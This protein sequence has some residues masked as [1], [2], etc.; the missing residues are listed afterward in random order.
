M[1]AN[2]D[3][4]VLDEA[5]EEG[6][7][8][9]KPPMADVIRVPKLSH[10]VA[11][12]L[13]SQIISGKLASGTMLA[14]ESKLLAI[15]DVSRPTLREA[16]RILEAEALIRIGRGMRAGAQILGPN[17]RKAAEYTTFMLVSEGVTMG[18]LHEARMFFEPP[19]VASLSGLALADATE[20]LRETVN[21]IKKALAQ[22]R[23][24]DVVAGT[25]RFHEQFARASGNRTIAL[26]MRMLQ[27]ISDDAHAVILASE[28]TPD[29]AVQKN[30]KKTVA[31]YDALCDLLE[32]GKTQE[33]ASFWRRYMERALEFLKR[34]GVGERRIV[35]A[36]AS[37]AGGTD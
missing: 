18:D 7:L 10:L 11:A 4:S 23:Y 16:L 3:I 32:K 30:M 5:T 15:F 36:K 17:L 6:E 33:A 24:V 20:H 35:P 25:N 34:S 9:V 22:R 1:C 31:G 26:L 37:G 29:E 2:E 12:R 27:S 21:R 28:T 13:R 14:P 19:I 8:N